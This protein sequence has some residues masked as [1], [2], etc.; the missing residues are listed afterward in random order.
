MCSFDAK[1]PSKNQPSTKY[2]GIFRQNFIPVFIIISEI[3][4]KIKLW[5]EE[6]FHISRHSVVFFLQL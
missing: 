2:Y 6:F 3:L 4:K 5:V 1:I